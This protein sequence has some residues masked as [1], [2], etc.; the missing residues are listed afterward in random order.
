MSGLDSLLV[1][2]TLD[3]GTIGDLGRLFDSSSATRGCWCMWFIIPVKDFHAGH[4]EQN[5]RLFA[6]LVERERVPMGLLA[7]AGSEPVGWIAAGPRSRYVRAVKTP[8]LRDGD[9]LENDSV[10]LVSCFFVRQEFRRRG[11]TGILLD[12]AVTL[13]GRHGALAVEGFPTKGNRIG[14]ADS[15][16]GTEYIFAKR[17]FRPV[18]EPSTNRVIMRLELQAR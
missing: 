10:W 15:Q 12:E 6:A 17:G 1:V 4:G 16:V 11:I 8:T 5:G 13:A 18:R 14:A 3:Q 7:Y 2:R 9:P